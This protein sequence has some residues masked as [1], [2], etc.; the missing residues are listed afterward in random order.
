MAALG[1]S[2]LTIVTVINLIWDDYASRSASV[3]AVTG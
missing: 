3:S 1:T 2:L